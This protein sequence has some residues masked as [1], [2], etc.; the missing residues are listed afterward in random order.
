MEGNTEGK[1]KMFK[2]LTEIN[3]AYLAG[4]I[5]G[6]GS[7]II[8]I[9]KDPSRNFGYYVRVSLALYQHNKFNW[10]MDWLKEVLAPHGYIT[11]RSTG[12]N[13]FVIVAKAPVKDLL[14]LLYP[15]LKIKKP[16]C[17]IAL[18]II[19]ELELV[20]TEVDFIKVCQKVDKV[21][22]LTYSKQRNVNAEVVASH[23]KLPVET[24]K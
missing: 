16:L 23:L 8:Q 10:F 15:Y 5:D 17:K 7:I 12:M 21:A 22:E 24:S 13:E 19:K 6:D 11:R 1:F 3:K 14:T 2:N 9:V 4:F 18:E 20:Q